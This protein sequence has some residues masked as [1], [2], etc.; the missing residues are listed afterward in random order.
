MLLLA[1][2]LLASAAAHAGQAAQAAQAGAPGKVFIAE[3]ALR[4][5]LLES[6]ELYADPTSAGEIV[7]RWPAGTVLE[8]AGETTDEFG[9]TWYTVRDP[10]RLQRRRDVYLA[11]FNGRQFGDFGYRGALLADRQPAL[12]RRA[13]VATASAASFS[14]EKPWWQPVSVLELGHHATFDGVVG[15]GA[16]A[17]DPEEL[18]QAIELLGGMASLGDFPEHPLP[19]ELFVP[20]LL[21]VVFQFD[22]EDW[23]LAR[24][25]RLLD[26]SVS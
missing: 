23:D 3:D 18:R 20:A 2:L 9:R 22:G 6:A 21:P 4:A 13:A 5:V 7:A 8:Y 1:L 14:P 12:A 15:I 25:I 16:T 19:G 11:P 10:N 24:P 17:A 26:D